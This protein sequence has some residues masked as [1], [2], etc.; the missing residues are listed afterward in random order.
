MQAQVLTIRVSLLKDLPG[1]TPDADL[2]S[3]LAVLQAVVLSHLD[4][5][6]V[7]ALLALILQLLL[8]HEFLLAQDFFVPHHLELLFVVG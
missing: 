7:S 3:D 4:D 2:L 1:G 6:E 5:G 8:P